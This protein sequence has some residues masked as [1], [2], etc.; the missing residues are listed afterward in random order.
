MVTDWGVTASVERS[1]CVLRLRP[2]DTFARQRVEERVR[3]EC[4]RRGMHARDDRARSEPE[5][6]LRE[7]RR[8]DLVKVAAARG[9]TADRS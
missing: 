1:A 9:C 4:R 8:S 3:F 2:G 7:N 6:T 5:G